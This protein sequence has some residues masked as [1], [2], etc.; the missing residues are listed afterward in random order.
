MAQN[1]G[2]PCS[3]HT[4]RNSSLA[5]FMTLWVKPIKLGASCLLQSSGAYHIPPVTE[6]H[7]PSACVTRSFYLAPVWRCCQ[8][9]TLYLQPACRDRNARI[10]Q[11]VRN[12]ETPYVSRKCDQPV[13][14]LILIIPRRQ[15]SQTQKGAYLDAVLCLTKKNAI[16]GIAGTVNRY[17][18]HQAVHSEQTPNIHWVVS[19]PFSYRLLF[20]I[21][22]NA[23]GSLHIVA[24]LFRSH[25]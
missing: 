5:L 14:S 8:L 3:R 12:G 18:D 1:F 21:L 4:A 11:S 6:T 16:S 15:L 23:L 13:R 19:L 22:N 9:D 20:S 25:L 7:F 17:D 2:V 24:P 10:R